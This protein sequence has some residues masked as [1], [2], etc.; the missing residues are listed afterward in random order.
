MTNTFIDSASITVPETKP[1]PAFAVPHA[2]K[3]KSNPDT[4]VVPTETDSAGDAPAA[5]RMLHFRLVQAG[6][7]NNDLCLTMIDACIETGLD[8]D[9]QIRDAMV[10]MGLKVGN[11]MPKLKYETG[12]AAHHRYR[13]DAAGRYSLR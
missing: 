10:A 12:N 13:L 8:T 7:K 9:K 6:T 11:F 4:I 2:Q 5:L 1:K 3:Q